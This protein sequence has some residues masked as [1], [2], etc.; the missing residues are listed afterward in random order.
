MIAELYERGLE[1]LRNRSSSY[2]AVFLGHGTATDEV[3]KDLARFCRAHES[4]FH[5]EHSM[6]DRLDGRREVWIRI[7]HHLNLSEEQLWSIYG[8]RSITDT[9]PKE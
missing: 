3:L 2:R 1:L 5:Y 4:T 7:A 9:E 6:S 8:N